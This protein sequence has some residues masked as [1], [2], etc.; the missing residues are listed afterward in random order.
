MAIAISKE[1][2]PYARY[3]VTACM[4]TLLLMPKRRMS[5][6]AAFLAFSPL[7]IPIAI[8]MSR[9]I[10]SVPGEDVFVRVTQYAYFEALC[11]LLALFYGC[12][13]IGEDV[14]ANTFTYMLTRPIPRSA[15]ALGKFLGYVIGTT[16]L[17]GVS[18]LMLFGLACFLEDFSVTGKNVGLLF[19]FYWA[20]MLAMGAYGA[21]G[22]LLGAL[23][24]RPMII[25]MVLFFGWQK[26]ALA[27]PG[28]TNYMTISKYVSAVMPK[29]DEMPTVFERLIERMGVQEL[30]TEV[31]PTASVV[32]LICIMAVFILL[33]AW[34]TRWREYTTAHAAGG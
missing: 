3:V 17:L 9:D 31:S 32:I 15:W 16:C 11:P 7:L 28:Y 12:A 8:L 6:L 19:K 18:M 14:E 25:G 34:V 29:I 2:P 27:L 1:A 23:A 33:T 22:L 24:K 10:F 30:I 26:L 20:L 13:L 4:H 21:V 5:L